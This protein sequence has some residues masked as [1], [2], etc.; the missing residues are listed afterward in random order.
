M[1]SLTREKGSILVI[2]LLL[3]LS[4][5]I[6]A[7]SQV[8][9]NSTQSRIA[10]NTADSHVAFQT[11]EGAINEAI[12]NLLAG[13]YATASFLSNTNGLYFY[14]A[15]AAPLWTTINWTS[16]SA[17]IS[18]FQ[19]SSSAQAVFFIELLPSVI[20]RGQNSNV[21]TQVYRI[22][23]RAVGGSGNTSIILQTTVQ[24]Q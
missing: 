22:T 6:I 11:A 7:V 5:T 17:V 12:N 13:S 1:S 20:K 14:N 16:N 23:A 2:S 4:L 24:V 9:F 10:A 21:P 3:M 19:G 8:S 15:S 18:S